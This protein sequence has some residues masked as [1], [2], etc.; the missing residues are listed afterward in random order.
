MSATTH[1]GGLNE[2]DT[3]PI[4]PVWSA[5]RLGGGDLRVPGREAQP[6][7]LEPDRREL[8][9]DALALLPGDDPGPGQ[10]YRRARLRPWD[11]PLGSGAILDHSRRPDRLS[12]LLL[13]LHDPD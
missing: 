4:A 11:R 5:H 12:Q 10:V 8:R 9:P 2:P 13:P 1:A 7:G 3:A 6:L